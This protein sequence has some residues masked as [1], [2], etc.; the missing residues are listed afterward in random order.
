M[1]SP[2][3][4]LVHMWKGLDILPVVFD[5]VAESADA[6]ANDDVGEGICLQAVALL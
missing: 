5:K 1:L 4:P 3:K 2:T 6:D